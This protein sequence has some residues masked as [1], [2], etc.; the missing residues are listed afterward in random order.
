VYS[1]YLRFVYMCVILD[2]RY[3]QKS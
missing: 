2:P 1:L 3:K